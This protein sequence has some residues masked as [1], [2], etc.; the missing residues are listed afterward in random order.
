MVDVPVP[1]TPAD[2]ADMHSRTGPSARSRM[3]VE[4]RK[5]LTR[6]ST[7]NGHPLSH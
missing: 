7:M 1:A 6:Q 3:S 2:A 5:L 4:R